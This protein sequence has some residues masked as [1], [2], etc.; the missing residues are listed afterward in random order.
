MAARV[1]DRVLE[2]VLAWLFAIIERVRPHTVDL[3]DSMDSLPY[4][5]DRPEEVVTEAPT[6]EDRDASDPA[7]SGIGD[8]P[9]LTGA[10]SDLRAEHDKIE[11]AG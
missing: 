7:L 10:V 3:G 2:R 5:A 9:D 1:T 4:I 11:A 6:E 8:R